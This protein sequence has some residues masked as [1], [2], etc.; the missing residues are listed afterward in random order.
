[1]IK[2]SNPTK[3]I[4]SFELISSGCANLNYKIKFAGDER[5]YILRIYI[6]DPDAA[7]IEQKIG[8]L[9]KDKVPVPQIY[10]IGDHEGY[11]FAIADFIYGIPLRDLLLGS[12]PHDISAIMHQVGATLG[13]IHS[14]K[15][16]I[17]GF[18]DKELHAKNPHSDNGLNDYALNCLTNPQVQK[19]LS[20]ETLNAIERFL[21]D[22]PKYDC[23]LIS[24]VHADFDPAN[25]IVAQIE[26]NWKVAAI[27]DWEF[28]YAGCYLNDIANM[29]RYSHQMPLLFSAAFLDGFKLCGFVL[30]DNWQM[31]VH[32]YNL[33]SML[34]SL[35]RHP[36]DDCPNIHQDIKALIEHFYWILK[37]MALNYSDFL[38]IENC[39]GL[40][41]GFKYNYYLMFLN[42][43]DYD[44][45][46]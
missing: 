31:I 7:F 41:W 8:A 34:D 3:M 33:A 29:L 21:K 24:L 2:L 9:L 22:I 11:R 39:V 12:V 18:F 32:Q 38:I 26:G 40:M 10:Y 20:A 1:M 30:P 37:N 43:C 23:G 5:P 45:F 46:I 13:Q 17:A 44:W 35:T 16:P 4:S 19:Y 25:I 36:I 28:A 15:F 14:I 42:K 27:L 6:R